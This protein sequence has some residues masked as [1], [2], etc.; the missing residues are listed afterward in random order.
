MDLAPDVSVQNTLM[1]PLE[2]EVDAAHH[3]PG[4][5]VDK[6]GFEPLGRPFPEGS[7]VL[8]AI[9]VKRLSNPRVINYNT[10]KV[11]RFRRSPLPEDL[12]GIAVV[13]A[14]IITQCRPFLS[15]PLAYFC[16]SSDRSCFS[17]DHG[18]H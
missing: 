2:P 6:E 7:E 9:A 1:P 18:V 14:L 13:P 12:K 15:D 10:P 16:F 3:S 4:L 5:L 8:A 11:R 17:L